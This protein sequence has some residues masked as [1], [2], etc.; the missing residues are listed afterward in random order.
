MIW[1]TYVNVIHD[2][3]EDYSQ[4]QAG[5]QHGYEFALRRGTDIPGKQVA[6]ERG[7][8]SERACRWGVS[9]MR[10][11]VGG[12]S[13]SLA[14]VLQRHW[15]RICAAVGVR[16][17]VGA[18]AAREAGRSRYICY[19]LNAAPTLLGSKPCSKQLG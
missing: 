5:V 13:D 17:P 11:V 2:E 14:L 16:D 8:V 1:T 7:M 15:K 6:M 4:E 9:R 19:L 10:T 3:D 18:A 12:Y